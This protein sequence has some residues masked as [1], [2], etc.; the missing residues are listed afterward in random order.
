MEETYLNKRVRIVS[1]PNR[2]KVGTVKQVFTS[3]GR[4]MVQLDEVR[5]PVTVFSSSVE[6]LA[7][8]G[9]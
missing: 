2:N 9:T 7:G 5:Q 4:L 6:V 8:D 3:T 1:G